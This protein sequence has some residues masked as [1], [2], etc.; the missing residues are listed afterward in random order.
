MWY[1]NFC[2]SNG[3]EWHKMRQHVQILLRL[4]T[5]HSY[6]LKQKAIAEEFP[7][8]LLS[9]QNADGIVKNFLEEAFLYSL[10]GNVRLTV[11]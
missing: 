8:Y 11:V 6:W 4:K 1:E 2:F 3:E 5:V 10:E 9:K 7:S